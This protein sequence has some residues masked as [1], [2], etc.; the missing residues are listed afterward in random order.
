MGQ[1]WEFTWSAIYDGPCISSNWDEWDVVETQLWNQQETDK[2]LLLK[3]YWYFKFKYQ[4]L[5]KKKDLTL[6]TGWR[7][8]PPSPFPFSICSI[9]HGSNGVSNFHTIFSL[10]N[11]EISDSNCLLLTCTQ[12]NFCTRHATNKVVFTFLPKIWKNGRNSFACIQ[13]IAT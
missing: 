6:V 12:T 9:F 5:K 2:H 3:L 7:S 13:C 8:F 11:Y 1:N 4:I 10:R